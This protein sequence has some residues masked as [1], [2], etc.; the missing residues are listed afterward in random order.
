M[1]NIF[2]SMLITGMALLTPLTMPADTLTLKADFYMPFNGDGKAEAGYVLDI[3]KAVFEPKGHKIVFVMTPWDKA[4]AETRAGKTNGV[5]GA[6][7]SDTPDFVFPSEEQ[8]ESVML[9]CVKAGSPWKFTGVDS[10]KTV[11]LGVIKDYTYVKAIDD[12]IKASPATVVVTTGDTALQTNLTML[13]EGELGA[14]MD[15]RSV[16][17]YTIAK[18]NLQGKVAFTL[19]TGEVVKPS[20]LFLAF[21][22]KH[23]KSVEYAKILSEGMVALRASGEL[24]KILAKYGLSEWK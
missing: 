1:R 21:S 23:P 5:I 8:G 12:F 13:A 24:Q 9:F 19:A 18:L 20:K 15:D 14:V 7:V 2:H 16:L 3:A 4:V 11:K 17:K 22:P 6:S 10:L